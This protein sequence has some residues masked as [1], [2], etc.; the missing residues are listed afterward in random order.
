LNFSF[1]VMLNALNALIVC[2]Q[3]VKIRCIITPPE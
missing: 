3:S 2:V 1:Q